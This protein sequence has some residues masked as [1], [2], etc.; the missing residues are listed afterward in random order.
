[1]LK[2]TKTKQKQTPWPLV[3]ERTI[4]AERPVKVYQCNPKHLCPKL[5]AYR[6]NG[7]REMWSIGRSTHYTYQLTI[8][9]KVCP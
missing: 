8:L 5:N 3:R 9:I 4:P 1:M 6:D 2:Y 7:Q